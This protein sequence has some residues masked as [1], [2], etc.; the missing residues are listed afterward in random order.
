MAAKY[1]EGAKNGLVVTRSQTG[2][3]RD[4]VR[5]KYG[6]EAAQ[7]GQ[8][9]GELDLN[10]QLRDVTGKRFFLR[11]TPTEFPAAAVAWQNLVLETV[12][13]K[14]L[15]VTTPQLLSQR[16]GTTHSEVEIDDS[17]RAVLRVTTWVPGKE[18][19]SFAQTPERVKFQ[20]GR[21]A[22]ETVDR[23]RVLNN[24]AAPEYEHHWML[25]NSGAALEATIDAV[26]DREQRETLDRIL[27]GFYDVAGKIKELPTSVVHQDIH[28]SNL[29]AT[30]DS[31]GGVSLSGLVD[32]NDAVKTIRIAELAVAASYAGFRQRDPF[33]A[34][35]KVIEGY[36]AHAEI[37]ELERELIYPLAAA[38]L[39]VNLSTWSARALQSNAAYAQTRME[40]TWPALS[41]YTSVDPQQAQAKI[42]N[43]IET[44]S[45]LRGS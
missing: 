3:L 1:S 35:C 6:I 30:R 15:S 5:E 20:I 21:V 28:D 8:L 32:F 2:R 31:T 43:A 39:A 17:V 42:F 25:T 24:A 9:A 29:L 40:A 38:S 12:T 27:T 13:Q 37:T 36:A 11:L 19:A 44:G 16:D 18:L 4:I 22:A 14:P 7:I 26:Q 45:Q 10:F 41:E 23:L 33:A 34:F